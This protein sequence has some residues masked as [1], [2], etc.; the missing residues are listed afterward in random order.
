M[1]TWA[2]NT[3]SCRPFTDKSN[4]LPPLKLCEVPSPTPPLSDLHREPPDRRARAAVRQIQSAIH[5]I[6]SRSGGRSGDRPRP[7]M[8]PMR[9]AR[10]T[11]RS[12]VVVAAT[13]AGRGIL[14]AEFLVD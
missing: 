2:V 7:E 8:I 1:Y 5:Q 10:A 4:P 9:A 3:N 14:R 6:S 12:V 11:G 13:A